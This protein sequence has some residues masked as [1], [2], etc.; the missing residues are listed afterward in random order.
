M[1]AAAFA[2]LGTLI[3]VRGT[4]IWIGTAL[5]L[6]NYLLKPRQTIVKEVSVYARVAPEHK[7]RVVQQL[8]KRGEIVAVTGDG[9]ND[10]PA[11]KTAHI[12]V[13]M[14][15]SG[16]DVAKEAADMVVTDDHFLCSK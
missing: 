1:Q 2:F 7:F 14:G 9:V 8:M 16:A 15:K 3:P 12:G 10:A 4:R 11:L 6:K 13:A 5:E